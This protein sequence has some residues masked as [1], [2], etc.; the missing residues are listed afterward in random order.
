MSQAPATETALTPASV[1]AGLTNLSAVQLGSMTQAERDQ[2]LALV[3]SIPG[4]YKVSI[5]VL[6]P[7]LPPH[8]SFMTPLY[9]NT[10]STILLLLLPRHPPS[11]HVIAKAHHASLHDHPHRFSCDVHAT[12]LPTFLLPSFVTFPSSPVMTYTTFTDPSF[13]PA[14]R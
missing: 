11:L 6:P 8:D 1:A 10:S 9:Y 14:R 5:Y 3:S 2:L 7:V 12:V 4:L 13:P